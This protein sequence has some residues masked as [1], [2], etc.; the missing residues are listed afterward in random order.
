MILFEFLFCWK[1]VPQVIWI[2]FFGRL[3][4]LKNESHFL[5][6]GTFRRKWHPKGV[7]ETPHS[8]WILHYTNIVWYRGYFQSS[9]ASG[10]LWAFSAFATFIGC[11]FFLPECL[12]L[13]SLLHIHNSFYS[14]WF[15]YLLSLVSLVSLVTPRRF[16]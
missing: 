3:G 15:V 2:I 8:L 16:I 5:K 14:F 6:K 10:T 1:Y 13:V 12:W 7:N 4:D 11:P 9:I